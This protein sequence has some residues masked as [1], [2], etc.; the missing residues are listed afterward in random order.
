MQSWEGQG[1]ADD[2]EEPGR[3]ADREER[4]RAADLGEP[5]RTLDRG[6]PERTV[7]G[8]CRERLIDQERFQ[9]LWDALFAV[10]LTASLIALFVAAVADPFAGEALVLE[11]AQ[12]GDTVTFGAYEQDGDEGNGPE[13]LRWRVLA[14]ES[15]QVLLLSQEGVACTACYSGWGES[16]SDSALCAWLAEVFPSEAFA[17]EERARLL[18]AE[19]AISDST[20]DADATE[21]VGAE[22]SCV[23]TVMS[24]NGTGGTGAPLATLLTVEQ[25]EQYLPDPAARACT[26][27]KAALGGRTFAVGEDGTMGW[28]LRPP[29]GAAYFAASVRR[30]GTIL[31]Y[32]GDMGRDVLCVRPVIGVRL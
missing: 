22:A 29:E 27:T 4:E 7:G 11:E 19:A 12:V 2:R 26:T 13:P 16:W 31:T 17:A 30:D 3:A 18:P 25:V 6:E 1:R 21:G 8:S 10:V 14:R 5:E 15:D 28:W 32:G 23:S 24:G 9:R 20:I